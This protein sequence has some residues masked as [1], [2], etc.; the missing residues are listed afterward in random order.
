M[1]GQSFSLIPFPAPN[2]PEITITGTIS[3]Q[4]GVLA[5]HYSLAG[6]IEAVLLPPPSEQPRR[7][8]ELWKTTCFEF[9]LAI[10]DQPQYWEFNMSPSGDWNIYHMDS[11]RRIGFREETSIPRLPFEGWEEAEAFILDAAVDLTPVLPA[12]QCVQVGITAIVRAKDSSETYWALRHPAS[13]A[14]FHLKESFICS[15]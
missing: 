9:F 5:L 8:D 1:T 3:R 2:L 10:N 4:N 7:K 14:D 6:N 12:D 15:V 13:H 11:Y